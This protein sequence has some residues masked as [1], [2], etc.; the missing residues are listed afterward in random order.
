MRPPQTPYN[1]LDTKRWND[2]WRW[3]RRQFA[4]LFFEWDQLWGL[5]TYRPEPG[6]AVVLFTGGRFRDPGYPPAVNDNQR[7]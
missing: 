2:V 5:V 1:E 6:D 4:M 3:M 7:G